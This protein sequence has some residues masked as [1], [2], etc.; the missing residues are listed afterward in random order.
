VKNLNLDNLE[1]QAMTTNK[2]EELNGGCPWVKNQIN[3]RLYASSF[4][5]PQFSSQFPTTGKGK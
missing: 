5:F 2:M 1:V 4:P 3:E